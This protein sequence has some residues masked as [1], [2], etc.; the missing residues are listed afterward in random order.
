MKILG[1]IGVPAWYPNLIGNE[2]DLTG[3]ETVKIYWSHNQDDNA[4]REIGCRSLKF[5]KE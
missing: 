3:G 5:I 2:G 4:I 1:S